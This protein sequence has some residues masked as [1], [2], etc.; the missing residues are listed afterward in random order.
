MYIV[1]LVGIAGHTLSWGKSIPNFLTYCPGKGT[2]G[3]DYGPIDPSVESNYEVLLRLFTEV[4]ALFSS[5][6]VH[7]GG[8]EVPFKCWEAN[9]N[10]TQWMESKGIKTYPELENYYEDRSNPNFTKNLYFR[11]PNGIICDIITQIKHILFC[12]KK[13]GS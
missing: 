8:D 2:F 4:T 12:K 3:G 7:L 5:K 9:S 11:N 10:L 1:Q 13:P 6:F